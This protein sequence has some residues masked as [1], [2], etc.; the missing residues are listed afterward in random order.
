MGLKDLAMKS[1]ISR[2]SVVRME[3]FDTEPI[4]A[5]VTDYVVNAAVVALG[6]CGVRIERGAPVIVDEYTWRQTVKQVRKVRK[7]RRLGE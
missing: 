1:N 4:S 5:P 3:A 7:L 2:I 6:E